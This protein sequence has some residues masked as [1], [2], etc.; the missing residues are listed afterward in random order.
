MYKILK[1][2]AGILGLIG[3]IFLIRILSVGDDAI[4]AGDDGSVDP[5]AYVA[6][7]T[8]AVTLIFVVFFVLKN[9]LTHGHTL[10]RALLGLAVF[11]VVLIIAYAVSGGDT[12]VYKYNNIVA[13]EGESHMVGAG[14]VAFYILIVAAAAA[15][16][17]SGIRKLFR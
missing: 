7:I 10:K 3:I 4:K 17:L 2:V 14:L 9:L 6:Y 15:M 12:T 5:M 13:T 1:I 16:F 11:A 8:L